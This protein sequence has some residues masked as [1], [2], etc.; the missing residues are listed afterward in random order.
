MAVDSLA[1]KV[2]FKLV[3]QGRDITEDIAALCTRL[4]VSASVEGESDTLDVDLYDP[5]AW[6]VA[7]RFLNDWFPPLG[8]S[9]ECSIGYEGGGSLPVTRYELDE[10]TGTISATSG[11]SLRL[12]C[13][14][15]PITQPA[16]TKGSKEYE[17]TTLDKIAADVAKRTGLELKGKVKPVVID[18][19]SQKDETPLEFLKRISEKHGLIMKVQDAKF[20]VFW[21]LED[22][23][24][25]PAA[26][27]LNRSELTNA[28][29]KRTS[30]EK[31]DSAELTYTDPQSGKTFRA[32]VKA[33]EVS[34]EK[35]EPSEG[36]TAKP[37]KSKPPEG[38]KKTANVLKISEPVGS[39]DEAKRVAKEKLR[40]ANANEVEWQIDVIG[41]PRIQA[42]VMFELLGVGRLSGNYLI[43]ECRHSVEGRSGWKTN[44]RCE[45]RLGSGAKP[46][47]AGRFD[48]DG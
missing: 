31:Y 38:E 25:Q 33:S 19:V 4:E 41:D 27:T 3:M 18:R 11:E 2:W 37:D 30:T 9:L 42:G 15:T 35:S 28:T 10:P 44:F 47:D 45:R 29:W 20:I 16:N 1:P 34:G 17:K 23:D 13:K 40:R 24:S 26:F 43:Q 32:T 12:S 8:A 36:D 21:D 48:T 39:D 22:L 5:D 7:G 14:S 46:L 6:L